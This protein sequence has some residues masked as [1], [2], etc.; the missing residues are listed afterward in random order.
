M[1]NGAY[2]R[3]SQSEDMTFAAT[4]RKAEPVRIGGER[5]AYADFF[6]DNTLPPLMMTRDQHRDYRYKCGDQYPETNPR[7][8][9]LESAAGL[10]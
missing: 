6:R 2:R 4:S 7:N 1:L 5:L 10:K 3:F 9:L 8:T